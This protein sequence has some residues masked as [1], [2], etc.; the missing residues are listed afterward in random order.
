MTNPIPR[1]DLLWLAGIVEGEGAIDLHRGLYPRIRV[2]M[3]DRDVVDR[4][5]RLLGVRTRPQLRPAPNKAMWHAELSGSRAVEVLE[6]LLPYMGA[7]RSQSIA[8]A[9]GHYKGRAS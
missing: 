1:D 8:T 7:R 3:T 9:L 2:G 4:V 5:A 6:Q